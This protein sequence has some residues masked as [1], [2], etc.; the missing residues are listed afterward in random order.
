VPNCF[1]PQ[2]QCTKAA[3]A[4]AA[5]LKAQ[6]DRVLAT[7]QSFQFAVTGKVEQGTFTGTAKPLAGPSPAPCQPAVGVG[8]VGVAPGVACLTP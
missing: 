5:N 6:L 2:G 4:S 7:V 1:L 3:Q 8:N